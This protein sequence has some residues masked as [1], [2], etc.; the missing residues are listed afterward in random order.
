[1]HMCMLCRDS[2]VSL[3]GGSEATDP[4]S[5]SD[6]QT[7][8]SLSSLGAVLPPLLLP[9]TSFLSQTWTLKHHFSKSCTTVACQRLCSTIKVRDR[10]PDLWDGMTEQDCN[11][12]PTQP[13]NKKEEQ[14]VMDSVCTPEREDLTGRGLLNEFWLQKSNDLPAP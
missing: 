13:S 12:L 3:L 14:D 9:L 7:P 6:S 10:R 2:Y 8:S 5:R 11:L 1:M 4:H